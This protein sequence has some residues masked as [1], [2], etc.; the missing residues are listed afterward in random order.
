MLFPYFL[1]NIHARRVHLFF[2]CDSL[3]YIVIPVLAAR[4]ISLAGTANAAIFRLSGALKA[5]MAKVC[6]KV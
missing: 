6:Y 4:P 3:F 5:A 2:I 1:F